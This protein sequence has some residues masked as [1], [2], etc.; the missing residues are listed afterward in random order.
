[1]NDTTKL[2]KWAQEHIADLQ[3]ERDTAVKALR[4]WS[5]TQT[6]GP[7]YVDEHACI[8]DEPG[9]RAPSH[10]KR[11]IEGHRIGIDWLG[12]KVDITLRDDE[13]GISYGGSNHLLRDVCL[14]PKFNQGL[15]L[16]PREKM[17]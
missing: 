16:I 15:A 2:P 13:I 8:N 14:Q 1:M 6:P 12:I 17:R 9:S 5:D 7:I 10:F 3:R 4:D 11:Y